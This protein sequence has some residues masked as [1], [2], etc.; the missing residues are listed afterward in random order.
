MQWSKPSLPA[1]NNAELAP[2]KQ[3]YL[4]EFRGRT[5]VV[6]L[7]A[8][9]L[10][11]KEP[12]LGSFVSVIEELLDNGTRLLVLLACDQPQSGVQFVRKI[13]G[14]LRSLPTL[15]PAITGSRPQF[16]QIPPNA[17]S[18]ADTG[19]LARAWLALREDRLFF[20]LAP[21]LSR[22][23]FLQL[24]TQLA[25]KLRV[26]KLVL[27]E[28]EGGIADTK[29]E[30]VP[31]MDAAMIDAVLEVGQAEWAGLGHRRAV[32]SAVRQA[33][34]EGVGSVNLC[35]L[36]GLAE[37]LFTYTGS[38]TLFTS[39][40]YCSVER[41]GIDDFPEVE[42][43]L[44][45]G[46]QEGVLKPR[47]PEEIARFLLHAYG[48]VVGQHHLAGVCALETELYEPD[49]AGE[50]V[51][52]YTITRFKG[53]GIGRKLLARVLADARTLGLRYVFACTTVPTA[54]AFFVREGFRVVSPREVPAAKWERYPA[55]R[56]ERV[57][58]LRR[59]LDPNQPES[60]RSQDGSLP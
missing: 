48:A 23:A 37:E 29:G 53:E 12:V 40:D 30:T 59:D 43:L 27:V 7:A 32:F 9:E 35:R 19:L 49:Q 20:L 42:R 58:V 47:T 55:E 25:G 24:A 56:R 51:G 5:L 36:A 13:S 28:P 18:S 2:E 52:L 16:Q 14:R 21:N 38:G 10:A 34:A 60:S 50:V 15:F 11:E 6:A 33:L 4:D 3:F 57:V 44:A 22:A 1:E 46:V 8:E 31:F 26:H 39:S 45:R 54:Q 41:L 17:P